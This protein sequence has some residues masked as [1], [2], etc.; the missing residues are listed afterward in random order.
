MEHYKLSNGLLYQQIPITLAANN[1]LR[2][3]FIQVAFFFFFISVE[4]WSY[5]VTTQPSGRIF[6][7]DQLV[8]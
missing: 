3:V 4:Y 5:W 1:S 8:H 6:E 2:A 7:R